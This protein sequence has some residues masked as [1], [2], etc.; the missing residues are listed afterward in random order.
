MAIAYDNLEAAQEIVQLVRESL[1]RPTTPP[2]VKVCEALGIGAILYL[3]IHHIIL[4]YI[5][6]FI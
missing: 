4:S 6:H 2:A 5:L 3:Y 1:V